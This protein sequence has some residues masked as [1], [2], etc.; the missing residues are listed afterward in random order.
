MSHAADLRDA[1]HAYRRYD[2]AGDELNR[3]LALARMQ[4]I[5]DA[6]KAEA[7]I[8]QSLTEAPAKRERGAR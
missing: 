5:H 3:S 4:A 7:A 6:I 2:D 8:R 1:I